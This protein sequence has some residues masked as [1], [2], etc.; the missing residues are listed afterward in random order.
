MPVKFDFSELR[1]R[2]IARYG[3]YATFAQAVGMSKSQLSERL[4]NVRPFKPDE[5][6][7]ICD[8]LVLCIPDNEIGKYFFTPKV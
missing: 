4:N 5:I 2:I 1:G 8:P 3:N 7:T 6:C